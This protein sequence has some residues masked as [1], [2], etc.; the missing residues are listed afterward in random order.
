M[1]H[2]ATQHSDEAIAPAAHGAR[3]SRVCFLYIAQEH[4]TLH[5]VSAAIELARLRPDLDVDLVAT[6]QATILFLEEV[7]GALGGAPVRLRLAGPSWLRALHPRGALPLKLPMLLANAPMLAGYDVIIAPERTTAALRWFGVRRPRLVYTQHGAGDRGGPFEPRLKAF[8]L[9][10]AAGPKQRDRM[11]KAGLVPLS[12]CAV[13][14]YPK[15]DVVD[16]MC[17]TP[18]RLFAEDRPIVVYNPH[19]DPK[20]SSWP[21]WGPAILAAFAAQTRYNLIFA[22]H[23]RLFEGADPKD[24]PSLAPFLDCPTI[25][26]DLGSRAAIDMTYT[27]MADVYLGDAS[28]QIYEFLRVR[29]PCLFLNTHHA[30]WRGDESYHHWLFGPVVE[31]LTDIVGAVD[32]ARESHPGYLPLQEEGFRNTFDLSGPSSSV[33]A[34]QAIENLLIEAPAVAERHRRP[35]ALRGAPAS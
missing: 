14:G 30:E 9:V 24:V 3:K 32:V 17:P 16:A 33:R 18:P 19:F 20:L 22:P 28:S 4:Q 6:S 11:A 12:R 23:I 15:F 2:V 7:I 26:L 35:S 21:Q 31:A 1:P 27:R 5:S 25:N 29:R 10:F 8:D 13:V 34:A